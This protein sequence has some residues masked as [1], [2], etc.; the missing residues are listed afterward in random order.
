[1]KTIGPGSFVARPG[2]GCA[3]IQGN[4]PVTS[5]GN[6][7]E[8]APLLARIARRYD[9]CHPDDSFSDLMRRAVFSKEDRRLMQDWLEAGRRWA[10]PATL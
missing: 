1:M 4:S 7:T 9:A 5:D 6:E 3:D 10:R 2:F 8:D